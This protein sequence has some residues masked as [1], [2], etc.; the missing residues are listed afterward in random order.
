MDKK[1]EENKEVEEEKKEEETYSDHLWKSFK[2]WFLKMDESAGQAQTL[3]KR[4]TQLKKNKTGGI[5]K[6]SKS[7]SKERPDSDYLVIDRKSGKRHLPVKDNGKP[8]PR[9]MGAAWA[10]LTKTFRGEK[11]KGPDKASALMK[12]KMLYKKIGKDVPEE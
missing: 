4:K 11:Y 6:A 8:N 2:Q 5:K 1:K 10:S 9:L 12:L 7:K 3:K